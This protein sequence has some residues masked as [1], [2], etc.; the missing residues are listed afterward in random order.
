MCLKQPIWQQILSEDGR[1]NFTLTTGP[2]I[3]FLVGVYH[4]FNKLCDEDLNSEA[5]IQK[6]FNDILKS[7]QGV[8]GITICPSLGV[9]VVRNAQL[10]SH[11][12]ITNENVHVWSKKLWDKYGKYISSHKFSCDKEDHSWR[13]FDDKTEITKIKTIKI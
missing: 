9:D 7:G 6:V 5:C 11:N 3:P 4:Y 2:T 13:K 8:V 1:R 10:I 12:P